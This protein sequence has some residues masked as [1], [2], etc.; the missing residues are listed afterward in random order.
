MPLSTAHLP[1][2]P[3]LELEAI[4]AS[5]RLYVIVSTSTITKTPG[6]RTSFRQLFVSWMMKVGRGR[7]ALCTTGP[8]ALQLPSTYHSG[9]RVKFGHIKT[10]KF[11]FRGSQA[12][13]LNTQTPA[14]STH[15]FLPGHQPSYVTLLAPIFSCT[16]AR[17]AP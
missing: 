14:C 9:S 15:H 13:A 4:K 3:G 12:S 17:H 8:F 16:N 10:T 11:A 6:E 7:F 2:G 5:C 1:S